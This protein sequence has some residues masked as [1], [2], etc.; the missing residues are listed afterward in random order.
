ME[1]YWET[2]EKCVA[3]PVILDAL[4]EAGF[5]NVS[6]HVELGVFSEYTAVR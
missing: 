6:R 5:S 2:I 1:Y 4:E 3:P